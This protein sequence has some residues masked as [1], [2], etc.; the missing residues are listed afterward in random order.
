MRFPL[1]TKPTLRRRTT[2]GLAVT[3]ILL[4]VACTAATATPAA[5][6][7]FTPVA[8]PTFT[9]VATPTITPVPT[10]TP[11]LRP[12]GLE[13]AS[14]DAFAVLEDFLEE[15]GPRESATEEELA[16]AQYLESRMRKLGYATELQTFTVESL[17]LAGM[18]LTLDTPQPREFAA[19]PL[20]STGLGDVSGVLTPVGLAMPGDIP[21]G[22]LQGRIALAKRGVIRF[23]SK[24]EN[25]F[26]AGAVGLVIYNNVSGSFQ[27]ALATEPE[28]PVISL[29]NEDGETI[30]A[31]LT[32]SEIEA[33]IV[34]TL[35]D[36]PS[37]NVIAE[38]K[39]PG[40]AVVVL[41]GHYDSVPGIS[42]ANDNAS[43]TA[44]L[45]AIADNLAGVDL[46][47]SHGWRLL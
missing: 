34:L 4:S 38:K 36:L 20:I 17:S 35:E 1:P 16:A 37:Q 15:L 31:L 41:G 7:T 5:T 13:S 32:E 21:E 26:A 22:G 40:D 30:E 25:V 33:S 3:L 9:P 6:P 39:G 11:P 8:A 46:R 14:A 43:G 19:L 47:D 45:L 42:G 18:G 44:V 10:P 24:A 29:S 28:F 23:Q 12:A 2:I 27:G